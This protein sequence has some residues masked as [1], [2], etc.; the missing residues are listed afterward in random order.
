[1]VGASWL[2][3]PAALA[4]AALQISGAVG[5]LAGQVFSLAALEAAVAFGVFTAAVLVYRR[6]NFGKAGQGSGAAG[7]PGT[8]WASNPPSAP[9]CHVRPRCR[10]CPRPPAT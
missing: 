7:E 1:M 3:L 6:S 8:P 9:Q 4:V 2:P 5:I 10:P